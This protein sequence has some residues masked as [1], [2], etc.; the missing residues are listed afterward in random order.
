MSGR[1][2][3]KKCSTPD[4]GICSGDD[5]YKPDNDSLGAGLWRE[6]EAPQ[7]FAFISDSVEDMDDAT[8][9]AI[10]GGAIEH[11]KEVVA[12]LKKY[13]RKKSGS[14]SRVVRADGIMPMKCMFCGR[15]VQMCSKKVPM[16]ESHMYR[17]HKNQDG[18]HCEGSHTM[19]AFVSDKLRNE[20]AGGK[21]H[22]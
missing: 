12:I 17:K 14:G 11:A 8:V 3:R 1:S 7:G 9:R 19:G 20:H 6:I 22:V 5:R 21:C 4:K 10:A 18:V 13:A 16:G 15:M 2:I